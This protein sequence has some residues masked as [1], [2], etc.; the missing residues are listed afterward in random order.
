MKHI[1]ASFYPSPHAAMDVLAPEDRTIMLVTISR[2]RD[3]DVISRIKSALPD[4]EIIN[5]SQLYV[6]RDATDAVAIPN[7]RPSPLTVRQREIMGYL[8]RGLSNKEIGRKLGLSHFTVRNHVSNIL[9]ILGYPCRRTMRR[10]LTPN[11][12]T[13]IYPITLA[14]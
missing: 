10:S 12:A 14:A 13:P 4:S 2:Y 3:E 7:E 5:L 11:R 8:L 6:D 9:R 1:D